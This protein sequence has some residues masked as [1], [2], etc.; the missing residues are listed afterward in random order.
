MPNA[1]ATAK[2]RNRLIRRDG[3]SMCCNIGRPDRRSSARR[4]GDGAGDVTA[5]TVICCLEHS[6]LAFRHSIDGHSSHIRLDS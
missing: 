3:Q 2:I 5:V 6:F 4:A 1:V